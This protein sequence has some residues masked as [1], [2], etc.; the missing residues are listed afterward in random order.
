MERMNDG[1]SPQKRQIMTALSPEHLGRHEIIERIG[2]GGMAIVCEARDPR[3]D[4]IVAVKMIRTLI[5]SD[6]SRKRFE[7]E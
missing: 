2:D 1:E 4:R 5:V 7:H 6:R 3:L